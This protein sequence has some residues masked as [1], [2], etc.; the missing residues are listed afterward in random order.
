VASFALSYLYTLAAL[1]V[2]FVG[3]SSLVIVLRQTMGSTSFSRALFIQVGFLV[4]AGAMLPGLLTQCCR[5]SSNN[6]YGIGEHHA[7]VNVSLWED[8][9]SAQQMGKL[10]AMLDQGAELTKLCTPDHEL[11][12]ALERAAVRP[13]ADPASC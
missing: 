4:A 6:Y 9:S 11:H 3:L 1:S 13:R 2:T 5:A 8:L 7:M 12:D 10:Q